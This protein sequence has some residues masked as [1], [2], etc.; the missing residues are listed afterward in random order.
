M[1]TT[2]LHRDNTPISTRLGLFREMPERALDRDDRAREVA[3]YC[4]RWDPSLFKAR[5]GCTRALAMPI[6][7]SGFLPMLTARYSSCPRH[8]QNLLFFKIHIFPI[9]RYKFNLIIEWIYDQ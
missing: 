8:N 2:V 9:Y 3:G 7:Y 5:Y 1:E 6:A 4:G